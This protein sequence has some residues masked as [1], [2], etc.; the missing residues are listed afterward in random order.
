VFHHSVVLTMSW[1]WLHFGLSYA[2]IGVLFNTFVHVI[3]YAYYAGTIS[4][5]AMGLMLAVKPYITL[6][7]IIQ[8]ASSFLLSLPYVWHNYNAGRID[9]C[10]GAPA[11]AFSCCLNAAFLFLFTRFFFKTYSKKHKQK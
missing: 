8:F 2:M 3:M 9:Y 4:K 5:T 10:L 11:F 6:L 7:Q 1:A